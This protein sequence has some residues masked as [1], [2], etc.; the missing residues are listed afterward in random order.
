VSIIGPPSSQCTEHESGQ[1]EARQHTD[2][3]LSEKG[4]AS[5]SL[6]DELW[7]I[8][9]LPG[10]RSSCFESNDQGQFALVL[11]RERPQMKVEPRIGGD[12]K[13]A[14]AGVRLG[15]A[16]VIETGKGKERRGMSVHEGNSHILRD[17]RVFE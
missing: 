16:N 13:I 14:V 15:A 2:L 9:S 11:I 5:P 4:L 1:L 12:W 10:C 7:Q 17:K 6:S 8:G 3:F